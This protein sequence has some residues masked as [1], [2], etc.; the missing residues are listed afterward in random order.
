[1]KAVWN[2]RVK[3]MILKASSTNTKE[4]PTYY[5]NPQTSTSTNELTK[6]V[7][8]P[9]HKNNHLEQKSID[10]EQLRSPMEIV[11]LQPQVFLASPVLEP[12]EP[13]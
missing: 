5:N 6:L 7:R 10:N 13:P 8:F 11:S 1:M 2:P 4:V 12:E 3:E 9:N